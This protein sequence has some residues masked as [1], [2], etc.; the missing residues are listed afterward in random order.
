[1]GKATVKFLRLAFALLPLFAADDV[2]SLNNFVWEGRP[3]SRISAQL[4]GQMRMNDH[5]M[6]VANFQG[7][8]MFTFRRWDLVRPFAGYYFIESENS[9]QQ[10]EMVHRPFL[11]LLANIWRRKGMEVSSRT[12]V[13]RVI[14]SHADDYTRFRERVG[15]RWRRPGTSPYFTTETLHSLQRWLMRYEGGASWPLPHHLNFLTGYQYRQ[16][17]DGHVGH[18]IVTTFQFGGVSQTGR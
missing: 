16:Y 13:E 11:G 3:T 4:L 18:I 7:G 12:M 15:W 14:G 6:N 2:E 8:P 10:F 5:M 17:G 9:R 1:M